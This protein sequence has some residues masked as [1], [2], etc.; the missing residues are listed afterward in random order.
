MPDTRLTSK[1]EQI[2]AQLLER[3][4]ELNDPIRSG[5]GGNDNGLRLM[6]HDAT[7]LLNRKADSAT[8][9]PARCSCSRRAIVEIERL[10]GSLR[11]ERHHIWWHVNERYL[12]ATQTTAYKCPKCRGVSHA[13]THKHRDKRG[14]LSTYPGTRILRITWNERVNPKKVDTGINWLADRWTLATEPMLPDELR[15]AA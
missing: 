1:R 12:R 3:W 15:I 2:I 11:D 9:T 8:W 10:L 5:N 7:C 4:T 14:K 13:A 6:P